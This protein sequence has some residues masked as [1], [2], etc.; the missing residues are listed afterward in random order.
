MTESAAHA[1][2]AAKG[3]REILKTSMLYSDGKTQVPKEV[4]KLLKLERGSL[5]VWIKEEDRIT[6]GSSHLET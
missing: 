4:I 1:K 6:V 2:Y 5:I 3:S